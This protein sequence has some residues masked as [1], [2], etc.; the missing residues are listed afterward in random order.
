MKLIDIFKYNISTSLALGTVVQIMLYAIGVAFN[1]KIIVYCWRTRDNNKSW[2]LHILYSVSCI[3]FFAFAI[4]FW[5]LSICV[6]HLSI[7]T[8]QWV[9][10]LA[11]FLNQFFLPLIMGNS[12]MVAITKYTI[13]VHWDK[14]LEY[15]HEKIQ[16]TTLVVS[17]LIAFY[18]AIV[19]TVFKRYH[20]GGPVHACFGTEYDTTRVKIVWED[21]SFLWCSSKNVS[22]KKDWGYIHIV[23]LKIICVISHG[24]HDVMRCNLPEAFFYYKIFKKMKRL[25]YKTRYL[26]FIA[27]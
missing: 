2:Q 1:I 13:I 4:P 14:A 15:G 7:H 11:L 18:N 27:M 5:L 16:L 9:C 19:K 24:L 26:A 12:L 21:I 23:L 3:M 25:E 10:Y 20:N 8:G 22:L 6:P 17:L